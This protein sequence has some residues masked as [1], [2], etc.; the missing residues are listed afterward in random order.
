MNTA[1]FLSKAADAHRDRVALRFGDRRLSYGELEEQAARLAG[2]LLDAGLAPGERLGVY[3]RNNPEY[4][5]TVF[6][7]FRAGLCVVPVN[8]KLHPSELAYI[9]SNAECSALVYG[10]E[11]STDV[12][13]AVS[14]LEMDHL[15]RVGAAGPGT[16]FVA[17]LD[18]G[19][20]ATPIA[21]VGPDDLAWLFYT[22]GTTGFPKGAMLTHRNLV[23][24]TMN[25]L[26][27][28]Y[29]FQPEDVVLHPA[30]LS[31]GCGLY[32]LA[33]IARGADN[34]IYHHASFNPAEMLQM[35]EDERV[36]CVAFMAPTMIVLLLDAPANIDTSS[37][38]SVIYGGGPMHVDIL[39]E[40]LARFGPVFVQIY[41]QGE[42]P[43]TISYLRARDH[44]IDDPAAL[45][46][47]GTARTDVEIR[48]VDESGEEV[49]AGEEGE[50]SVRGDVVMKGYWNNPEAT[51]SSLRN[52]WLHTGDIG[53]LDERGRLFL[54]DR[55]NDMIIS[56]G[57][58][59]YPREVEEALIEHPDVREA[60]V[61]GVPDTVWGESVFACV[62]AA[63]GADPQE[64]QLIE[65]CKQHLASFKKPKRVAIV[66]ELP[67]NAY[68][69]VLRRELKEQYRAEGRQT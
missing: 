46:S 56:G 26:A 17:L 66:D 21:E 13:E 16:D 27:D 10:E 65:F 34:I 29:S 51:A 28:V 39:R 2:A 19:S 69:K 55:K 32:A 57:T 67:K 40:A 36:S 25:T 42:A 59:I 22:S 4:L 12:S 45:A 68:G 48:M 7:A 35:V 60:V 24:M 43:M 62:V 18:A 6:A 44:D 23:A 37:L 14:Q 15:V 9:L 20:P 49:A 52:G 8:A 41:G 38:R 58:N 31:H 47:T 50:V 64:D 5:I 11:K 1:A 63:H 30:P 33:S 53:R 54:L 61:F 3:M